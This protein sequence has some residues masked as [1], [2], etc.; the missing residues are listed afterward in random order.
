MAVQ[1]K[2]LGEFLVE[3][4]FMSEDQ[5]RQ[6]RDVQKTAPGDLGNI[7]VDL[8]FVSERNVA[9][10]R[11]LEMGLPFIDLTRT[12]IDP[13]LLKL[14]PEHIVRR[15]NVLPV[16][17]ESNNRLLVAVSDPKSTIV[18]LDDIRIVSKHQPV[19]ALATKS[20]IEDTIR[21]LYAEDSRSATCRRTATATPRPT[22][23][24]A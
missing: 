10:C 8:G 23:T 5:L 22:A 24:V 6:A 16:K 14:V 13:E 21:K 7:I 19:I 12:Q 2:S 15:Y 17:K 20:D 18:A 9:A 4:G 3:K 11:A 1:K